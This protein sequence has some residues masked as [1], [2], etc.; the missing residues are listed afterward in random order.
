MGAAVSQSRSDFG[1]LIGAV[2][3]SGSKTW[4]ASPAGGGRWWIYFAG[5]HCVDGRPGSRLDWFLGERKLS[6]AGQGRRGVTEKFYPDKFIY[7][8]QEDIFRCPAGEILRH[9]GRDF[10]RAVVLSPVSGHNGKMPSLCS[11]SHSAARGT[12]IMAARWSGPSIAE[13][14]EQFCREDGNRSRL[15]TFT[16]S[17]ERWRNF[18]MRGSKTNLG[19]RQFRLR[20]LVKVRLEVLWAALTY[21]IQQWMRLSWSAKLTP[22]RA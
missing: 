22:A 14:C 16:G 21:N 3:A 10:R 19:L 9:K 17:A 15:R 4:D 20:G 1:H 11:F 5:K 18:P 7:D 6:A 2:A 13:Y 8:A 12:C